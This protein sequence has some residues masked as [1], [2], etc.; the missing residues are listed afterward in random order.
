MI[1]IADLG[2]F[3]ITIGSKFEKDGF[4]NARE[5]ISKLGTTAGLMAAAVLAAA[6]K[7]AFAAGEQERAQNSLAQAMVTAG[8]WTEKAYKHN[9]EYAASLQ[10]MTEYGDEAIIGVQRRL[11]NF[12]I[13]G[14]ALDNLTR[15]TIDLA[16]AQEMDLA[17]AADLVAKTVGSTTNSLAR[18]GVKIEGAAG[19]TER[20]QSAV[21]AISGLWGGA[22][23]ANADTFT[24]R[25]TQLKERFGEWIEDVGTIVMPIFE[26]FV[27]F[28]TNDILPIM[29]DWTTKIKDSG[30]G[31]GVLA[32]GVRGLVNVLIGVKAA[33][34]IGTTAVSAFFDAIT[35]NIKGAKQGI[36]DIKNKV[37]EY[38]DQL[39]MTAIIETKITD[40]A[41]DQKTRIIKTANKRNIT[42]EK[43]RV[44]EK[45]LIDKEADAKRLN[46]EAV[47]EEIKNS[48]RVS[49]FEVYMNDLNS[50]FTSAQEFTNQLGSTFQSYYDLKNT[51]I[52]NDMTNDINAETEKYNS[53]KA[54]IIANVTDETQRNK[55][56]DNLEEG[57]ASAIQ[58]IKDEAD[59][60]EK[61]SK[62]QMKVFNIAEA[63]MNTAVGVT[64][65]LGQGGFF[66]IGMALLVAAQGAM[67]IAIIK[68]QKFA[69]G[70][71]AMGPT[72]AIFGEAGPELALPLN[73]PNTT[74]ALADALAMAGGG[75][76]GHIY[77]TVP[78]ISTRA[79][80]RRMGQIV[81]EEI[82]RKVK[83]NRKV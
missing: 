18:Y 28:I 27:D 70:G 6:T 58:N 47:L 54:W 33:F 41:E 57:H 32:L 36:E 39:K 65:A 60:K 20:A 29:E 51:Q 55:M 10:T 14:K 21:K 16:A 77:V 3:F 2:K 56:L 37:M 7:A 82:Y 71:F 12:G 5:S 50:K 1:K 66:G 34:D 13:E 83:V 78:P 4:D 30:I 46:E 43:N 48:K 22:A 64:K 69:A 38:A 68:A 52:Q 80:A 23:A 62:R 53:R 74:R 40:R 17:S 15:A 61:E 31:V 26:E 24:G 8:T 59:R 76:G 79:E 9:L 25:V 63:V 42:A 75:G 73:H 72:A 67:Q 81:G 11:S 45:E 49:D 35:G 44:E 19:S